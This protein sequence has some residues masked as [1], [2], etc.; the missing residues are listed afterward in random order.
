MQKLEDFFQLAHPIPV[1]S[2]LHKASVIQIYHAG[3]ADDA[4]L[5]SLIGITLQL[6]QVGPNWGDCSKRYIDAA[7]TMILGD[8]ARPSITKIQSLVF[9]IKHHFYNRRFSSAFVLLAMAIRWAY[10]LR[11]NYEAPRLRFVAQESRRRLMWSLYI[12]DTLSAAGLQEFSLSSA[13]TMYIQ[14]PCEERQFELDIT[15]VTESLE[16]QGNQSNPI[17]IG[18]FALYVR[19]IWLRNKILQ[20]TKKA[21]TSP[22]AEV[23]E[24]QA[25]LQSLAVDLDRFAT[26]LPE[27]FKFSE[28]NLQ[29]HAYSGRVYSFLLVHVWWQQCRCDLYRL[30]LEGLREALPRKVLDRFDLAF[31]IHCRRQSYES[32]SEMS[33]IFRSL[34]SLKMSSLKVDNDLDI[35]AYQCARTLFYAYRSN[36]RAFDIST[37]RAIEQTS[38]CLQVLQRFSTPSKAADSLVSF[39]SM[40]MTN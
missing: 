39:R 25:T 23:S 22:N 2:F 38:R 28:S 29:L 6:K 10:G 32:A 37:P 27:S 34:L 19:I 9:I 20:A 15:Q 36:S 12:L 3:Q 5:L 35:C 1:F 11:L 30:F 16:L 33:E 17:D 8:I 24:L 21:A 26:T 13:H 31:I 7:Q 4:L 40:R 14:L 18:S